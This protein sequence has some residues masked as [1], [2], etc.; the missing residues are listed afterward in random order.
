MITLQ[1]AIEHCVEVGNRDDV[2]A[3]CKAQH[4]QLAEWLQ[5]LQLLKNQ[6][7]QP[8]DGV[9]IKP[10]GVNELDPCLY[11][12]VETHQNV[13]V[14]VLRCRRCGHI[15]IEWERNVDDDGIQ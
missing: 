6:K 2:C 11:D 15:E 5:E 13:T 1:E 12:E 9:S 14:H 3:E 10:D 8:P 7:C 4:K